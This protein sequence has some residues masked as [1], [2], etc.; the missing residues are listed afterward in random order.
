MLLSPGCHLCSSS[1]LAGRMLL[2][3][4]ASLLLL[5]RLAASLLLALR[6]SSRSSAKAVS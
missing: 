4:A 2:I 3:L 1:S 5:L 6:C